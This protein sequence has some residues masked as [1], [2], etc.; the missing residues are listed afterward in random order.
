VLC[1]GLGRGGHLSPLSIR[2]ALATQF[3]TCSIAFALVKPV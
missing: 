2:P 3:A 1:D